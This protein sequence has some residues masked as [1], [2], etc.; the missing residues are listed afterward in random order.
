MA[1]LSS[2]FLTYPFPGMTSEAGR[3]TKEQEAV[4]VEIKEF[5]GDESVSHMTL[6]FS[7]CNKKQTIGNDLKFNEKLQ[8]LV[9]E[10]GDRW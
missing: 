6:A 3:F 9:R 10:T 8:Q 2:I 7:K 4:I 1:L 5:L